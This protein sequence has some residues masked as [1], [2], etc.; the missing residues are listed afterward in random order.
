MLFAS[1]EQLTI[2]TKQLSRQMAESKAE[3][4]HVSG[5]AKTQLESV[6][7]ELKTTKQ[8]LGQAQEQLQQLALQNQQLQISQGQ[9]R[10]Q[11]ESQRIAEVRLERDRA[12]LDFKYHAETRARKELEYKLSDVRAENE[13]LF[14]MHDTYNRL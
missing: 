13:Q 5:Q 14:C 1:T 7:A 6:Q 11:L 8:Q 4:E 2:Q 9:H 3:A 12:D 10:A